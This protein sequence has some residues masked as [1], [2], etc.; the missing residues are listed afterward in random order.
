VT[1][2]LAAAAADAATCTRCALSQGRTQVVYGAGN[3]QARLLFVGE[4]PGFHEDKQGA[5]FVGASGKLLTGL[6]E[7]I[8][9]TRDDVYI[10]NVL[11]C[12]PPG[13]RDPL[14]DEID[15]CKPWLKEQLEI[16]D[17]PVICTLGNFASKLL[18][19]TSIGISRLRGRRIPWRG[20][21]LIPTF[22]PAAVLHSG[23]N[24]DTMTAMEQDFQLIAKVLAERSDPATDAPTDISAEQLGLF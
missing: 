20:R 17:P 18:L 6:I 12:R 23:R 14:P 21:T 11:K 13:N 3:P 15:T 4:A 10:A 9:L 8:G 19:G 5:P 1:R 16:I 2:T 7:G 22:H 24:S